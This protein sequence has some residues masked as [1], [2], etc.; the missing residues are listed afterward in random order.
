MDARFCPLFWSGQYLKLIFLF[1]LSAAKH[2]LLVTRFCVIHFPFPTP[3]GLKATVPAV[4]F[5][6]TV[7]RL[8]VK[9]VRRFLCLTVRMQ[10]QTVKML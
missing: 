8:P 3:G 10:N 9:A 6:T 5:G 2:F 1:K 7:N 4:L